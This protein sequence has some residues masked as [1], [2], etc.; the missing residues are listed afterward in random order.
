MRG[1][2]GSSFSGNGASGESEFAALFLAVVGGGVW[3][4]VGG[5]FLVIGI[6]LLRKRARCQKACTA[7]TTGVVA[8]ISQRVSNKSGVMFS[9]VFE[10]EVDGLT[11]VKA[12]S[13]AT[14]KNSYAIGETIEVRYDPQNPHEY[15]LPRDGAGKTLGVVFTAVGAVCVLIGAVWLP[16]FLSMAA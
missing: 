1:G 5:V 10:Y 12:S 14:S 6:Y 15:Y 4:V 3:L 8:D 7:T 11:Y 13:T 9:P 16:F 2:S